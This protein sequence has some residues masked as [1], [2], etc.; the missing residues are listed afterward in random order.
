MSETV[1]KIINKII[2][3][4]FEAYLVGGYVRS[5]YMGYE[6]N[7]VDIATSAKVEDLKEIF[8]DFSYKIEY[9]CLAFRFKE[10]LFEISPYR[11]EGK[12]IR[13]RY[14]KE[15]KYARNIRQDSQRRDFTINSIYMDVD[16]KYISFHNGLQDLEKGIIRTIGNP[17]T[18]LEED[19]LRILRAIRFSVTLHFTIDP[20][21]SKALEQCSFLI[22]TLSYQ[23]RKEELTKML[24]ADPSYT[25]EQIERYK[26]HTYFSMPLD[27]VIT[28]YL[29]AIWMQMDYTDYPLSRAELRK[30]KRLEILMQSDFSEETLFY[31]SLEEIKAICELKDISYIEIK[32]KWEKLPIHNKEEIQLDIPFLIQKKYPITQIRMDVLY[33]ILKGQFLNQS[34]VIQKYIQENYNN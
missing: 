22:D 5:I 6:N 17:N 33:K 26:L 21:L 8:K 27:L 19:A 13:N 10:Y 14:P 31:A 30:I 7:D 20:A 23:R 32:E 28:D 11:K 2:E 18:R 24:E 15:I 29:P 25:L 4:G 9:N 34:R 1:K 12:Y 16:G 3:S